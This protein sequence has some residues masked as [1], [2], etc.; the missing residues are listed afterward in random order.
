MMTPGKWRLLPE[1]K[2]KVIIID[3]NEML[4]LSPF[5]TGHAKPQ[6]GTL[7]ASHPVQAV[8]RYTHQ[9]GWAS[10]LRH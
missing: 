8:D 2:G 10:Q 7:E 3:Q 5:T 4:S 9:R 1:C 6:P